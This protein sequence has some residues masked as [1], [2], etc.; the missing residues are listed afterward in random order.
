MEEL[1]LYNTLSRQKEKFEPLNPPFVGMYVC[2]PTVYSDAHLGHARAAVVFDV[3]YRYLLHL[4]YNVRFV[5]NV[6]DVGH[7]E[8]EEADAGEDKM[9]K[10]AKAMNLEPMEVAQK[11]L[12]GYHEDLRAL[13]CLRPSIEPHASGH[14]PEQIEL[15]EKLIANGYAY[16]VNGSVYFDT[17]AYD[18]EFGYG[19]LSGRKMDELLSNTRDGLEGMEEKRHPGDF[20]LWKNAAPEH[21][22][23]WKSP[24]GEGFPGWHLEC[25]VMSTK[26]LGVKYDIHGG[27]MDLLFPHHEAEI[28]QSNGCI[29]DCNSPHLDEAKY[30]VHNNM[31]T[32]DGVK[33]A[34]S[35]GNFI[36]IQQSYN[37]DHERLSRAYDPMEIRFSILQ[38]HY[39]SLQDFS[40]DALL[41]SSKA[42]QR[43][44]EALLRLPALLD[45]DFGG[46]DVNEAF[47]TNLGN[48]S[49]E[50]HALMND[51]MNTSRV[52]ARMFDAVPV[53]N[54]IDANKH[55]A[56]P[57]KA[58][59]LQA[60]AAAFRTLF[61]D[62]LGLQ[63]I[64]SESGDDGL[65]ADL[66]Q[67][68]I[69]L[70]KQ[71]RADKNWGI[72]DQIRDELGN[73]NIKLKDTPT[74]TEWYVEN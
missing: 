13:N 57:V 55:K 2:G 42:F 41:A 10:R 35:K 36:T 72:S 40:D 74:G 28:A 17:V 44:S 27:G 23:R 39:R 65:S 21:I 45:H 19:K 64:V 1:H 3:L 14:I 26:Y 61:T 54:E 73:L 31:I 66:M 67:L 52:I 22:M 29:N 11:Y 38:A 8:N 63:P 34:K 49:E 15:V 5:R 24:W 51:D 25:T 70:R 53:I 46:E 60:F 58:A 47:E 32:I 37:G 59:T 16:E 43:L 62:V 20:A 12:N 30:W 4:D 71:A 69:A 48:F 50:A 56:L 7:L 68:I 33:M 9:L 18:K 6:T